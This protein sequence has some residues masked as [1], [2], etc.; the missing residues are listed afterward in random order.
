MIDINNLMQSL[1]QAK[2]Q[3][4]DAVKNIAEN[5]NKEISD[6]GKLVKSGMKDAFEN[7]DLTKLQKALRDANNIQ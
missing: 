4:D 6:I 1:D 3:L 2:Q 7:N 5:E